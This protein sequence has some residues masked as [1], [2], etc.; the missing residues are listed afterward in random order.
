[1]SA[2]ILRGMARGQSRIPQLGQRREAGSAWRST[3]GVLR[4]REYV[5]AL[6]EAKKPETRTRRIEG[7]VRMI[8]TRPAKKRK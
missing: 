6:E 4:E 3:C 5:Q 7:A 1:M 8:A 2:R